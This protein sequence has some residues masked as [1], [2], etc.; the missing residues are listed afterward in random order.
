VDRKSRFLRKDALRAVDTLAAAAEHVGRPLQGF[1]LVRTAPVCSKARA[2]LEEQ[3]V[4]VEQHP[5]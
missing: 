4:T 5:G 1:V 3:G 2:W